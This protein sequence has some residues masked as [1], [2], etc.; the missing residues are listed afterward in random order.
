MKNWKRKIKFP[1]EF[2]FVFQ[3]TTFTWTEGVVF[4][5]ESFDPEEEAASNL[6]INKELN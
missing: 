5:I 4:R 6:Q 2:F 3:I 1:I